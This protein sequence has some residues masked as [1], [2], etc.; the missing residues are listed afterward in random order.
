MPAISPAKLKLQT[1]RLAEQYTQPGIFVRELHKLLSS[2]ADNTQRPSQ[3]GAPSALIESYN[4]HTPVMRQIQLSLKA[5]PANDPHGALELCDAL[6]SEPFLEHRLLAC[7]MLGLV[8][9]SQSE[10]IV[11]RLE[12]WT[13][14]VPEHR[15]LMALIDQGMAR[16]RQESPDMVL[17]LVDS[18]LKSPDL[19]FQQFGLRAL[20][21]L[22]TQP[23]F[24]N[25]PAVFHLLTPFL[26]RS[27]TSI[28]PD[29]VELLSALT[30]RFPSET[31]YTLKT[32]LGAADNPDTAWIIRQVLPEFAKPIQDGLKKAM[33]NSIKSG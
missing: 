16:L 17:E 25:L 29:M 5:I 6:W 28:R 11:T 3:S 15:L 26:R 13:Q 18:W 4:V 30:Q 8:P 19:R 31:A 32:T 9:I 24:Q 21:P 33:K 23:G 7:T 27:P 14:T 20:L 22:V 10:T 12:Y 2:Y 1:T